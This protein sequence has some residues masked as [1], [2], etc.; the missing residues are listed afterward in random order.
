MSKLEQGLQTAMEDQAHLTP[1][2]KTVFNWIAAVLGIG[3]AADFVPIIV[4]VLSAGWI[5]I[6][7]YGYIRYEL[8]TKRARL[9]AVRAG[10]EIVSV[11]GDPL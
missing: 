11:S 2:A 8:P 5:F 4:G 3:S 7:L 10:R 9:E 6:Q 1:H